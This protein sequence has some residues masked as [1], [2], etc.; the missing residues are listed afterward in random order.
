MKELRHRDLETLPKGTQ[1]VHSGA[2]LQIPGSWPQCCPA[3]DISFPDLPH[4]GHT[5]TER[6]KVTLFRK[7][8]CKL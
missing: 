3:S 1:L 8:S 4:R 2:W 6:Q 5:G 7:K